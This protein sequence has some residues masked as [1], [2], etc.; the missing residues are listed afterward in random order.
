MFA[1]VLKSLRDGNPLK[2]TKV[3]LQLDYLGRCFLILC[4]IFVAGKLIT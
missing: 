2:C 4:C 3:V 1:N